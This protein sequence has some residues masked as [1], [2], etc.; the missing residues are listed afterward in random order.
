MFIAIP[1]HEKTKAALDSIEKSEFIEA[2]TPGPWGKPIVPVLKSNGEVRNCGDFFVTF[3]TYL[4][5]AGQPLLL[6][7]DLSTV[8]GNWFCIL[9]MNQAYLQL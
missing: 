6:I 3:N 8:S 4:E 2:C 5:V 9:D 1:L 7:D